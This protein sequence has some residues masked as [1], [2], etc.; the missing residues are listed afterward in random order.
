M[1]VPTV[2]RLPEDVW[3]HVFLLLVKDPTVSQER[4]A[5]HLGSICRFWREIVLD[6]PNLWTSATALLLSSKSDATLQ[7]DSEYL[8]WV[9]ERARNRPVEVILRSA[10]FDSY[11]IPHMEP[12]L[13]AALAQH[14]SHISRLDIST[15]GR[16]LPTESLTAFDA[17][18]QVTESGLETLSLDVHLP[19]TVSSYGLMHL[20]RMSKGLRS[21]A[22]KGQ[23]LSEM[24]G[25]QSIREA[26]VL[27]AVETLDISY[28][29]LEWLYH[30]RTLQMPLLKSLR[31]CGP[32]IPGQDIAI[33]KALP[34]FP[35]LE[36]LKLFNSLVGDTLFRG[37]CDK[38]I[39][40]NLRR[41]EVDVGIMDDDAVV[42]LLEARS[43]PPTFTMICRNCLNL[44]V[45]GRK[46]LA[47]AQMQES[48]YLYPPAS[49]SSEPRL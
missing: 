31:L 24:G 16:M 37:L 45:R 5:L 8:S 22:V 1:N 28:P 36:E 47:K 15:N 2:T 33:R 27:G 41:L 9:L 38:K 12:D 14:M 46:A 20:L 11:I 23:I 10:P 18:L 44:T 3:R 19:A 17:F 32:A 21:L 39:V 40:P 7:V 13:L 42:G 25:R 4:T 34:M 30:T 29:V 35:S 26:Q 6:A 49:S 43:R 48:L